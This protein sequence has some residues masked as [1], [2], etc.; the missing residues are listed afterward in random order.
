MAHCEVVT[1]L[2][3]ISLAELAAIICREKKK[4]N[5]MRRKRRRRISHCVLSLYAYKIHPVC[6][7]PTFPL[8]Q[9]TGGGYS[10]IKALSQKLSPLSP[11]SCLLPSY[12]HLRTKKKSQKSQMCHI[13]ISPHLS[14]S[15]CVT[16]PLCTMYREREKVGRFLSKSIILIRRAGGRAEKKDYTVGWGFDIHGKWN[17]LSASRCPLSLEMRSIIT[18][19]HL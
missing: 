16:S 13:H 12:N 7:Q 6:G 3:T 1:I 18:S 2:H 8:T 14:L 5:Q 9:H 4:R 10:S 11:T 19:Q 15:V 17:D